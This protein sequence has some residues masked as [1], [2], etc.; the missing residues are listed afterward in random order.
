[1]PVFI[2]HSSADDLAARRI[3][4][5]LASKGITC[6]LDGL[7]DSLRTVE[8]V[9]S[10]IESHLA[11]CT[12]LLAVVSNATRQ[13]WWVPFEIGFGTANHKRIATYRLQEVELPQ[14]LTTWPILS[15]EGDLALYSRLYDE[16]KQWHCKTDWTTGRTALS[17]QTA[18]DFHRELK[19]ALGQA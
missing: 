3:R 10:A 11:K 1:M 9:T 7:D 8:D 6:Y 16:G 15:T 5:F 18:A 4:D 12:H 19:Q 17:F 14:Y 2:S 13:S